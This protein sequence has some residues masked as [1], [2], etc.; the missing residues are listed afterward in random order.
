MK[1]VARISNLSGILAGTTLGVGICAGWAAL[2]GNAAYPV[3]LAIGTAALVALGFGNRRVSSGEKDETLLAVQA[4]DALRGEIWI[5]DRQAREVRFVN[6]TA[7]LRRTGRDD[8]GKPVALRDILSPEECDTFCEVIENDGER[9]SPAIFTLEGRTLEITATPMETP[10]VMVLLE[11]ISDRTESERRKDDFVS[12]VSHE[13]RSPL[14]SIK[15]SMGLLLSNAAGDLP[16]PARGLIE[17]AHRNAERLVLILN[18]M[19]D[20]EKIAAGGMDFAIERTDMAALV[21]EAEQTSA[22]HAARFDLTIEVI[23]ADSPAPINTDANRIMQVLNNLLTNAAKFSYAGGKITIALDQTDTGVRV[24]V[25]DTGTG[26]PQSE[27]HK[28]FT[29][30]AD[31]SNSDRAAKG[32][33]GLGLSISKA[34]IEGLGGSIGFESNQNVGTTFSFMLPTSARIDDIDQ[35]CGKCETLV[36]IAGTKRLGQDD[37]AFAR[38][39]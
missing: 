19:L 18:D 38:R 20:L 32:G 25:H 13:L 9:A 17:I 16:K 21:R 15:G 29:R 35:I 26:I 12:T 8:T 11:D 3:G 30:F 4:L 31:M 1:H 5:F 28:I 33:T 34:I 22:V 39:G 37:Q 36:D 27:Q 10:L 23:G 14:T 24:S 2:G 7:R 6:A